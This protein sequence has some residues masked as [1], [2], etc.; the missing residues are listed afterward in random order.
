MVAYGNDLF[1]FPQKRGSRYLDKPID[2]NTPAHVLKKLQ[3]SNEIEIPPFTVHDLRR[4]FA[5]NLGD[6]GFM[7]DEIGLL[8]NHTRQGVTQRY[9]RSHHDTPKWTMMN[10]W[11][12]RLEES[13]FESNVVALRS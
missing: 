6:L 4:T 13:I 11:S 10:A 8:L 5:T 3:S 7:D 9:N 12:L 2:P 1:L